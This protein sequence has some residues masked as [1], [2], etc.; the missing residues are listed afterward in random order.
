MSVPVVDWVVEFE[1]FHA[2]CAVLACVNST[3]VEIDCPN[4]RVKFTVCIDAQEHDYAKYI[5]SVDR[6]QF[7][8]SPFETPEQAFVVTLPSFPVQEKENIPVIEVA[9]TEKFNKSLTVPRKRLVPA[10]AR[11]KVPDAESVTC[12]LNPPFP[13]H[14]DPVWGVP[15]TPEGGFSRL[16][17]SRDMLDR[18]QIRKKAG[19][20]KQTM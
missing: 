19:E 16:Q 13:S 3:R 17:F 8:D 6:V 18:I 11:E 15:N 10:E 12:E 7:R 9:D 1:E 14:A 20:M 5:A 2:Q 4:T